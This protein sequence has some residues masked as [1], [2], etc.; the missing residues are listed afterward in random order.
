MKVL[1]PRCS[2]AAQPEQKRCSSC[3]AILPQQAPTGS[4]SQPLALR[5]GI[6][7]LSPTYH[8]KT[9]AIDRLSDLVGRLMEGEE[10]FD[11]LEDHLED[12]AENF[13]EFEEKYAADMQALLAQ[14]S[15]RFPEDDYNLQLSYLLRRGLQLFDEGCRM[16]E[17]FFEAE[18]EDADELDAA[19]RQVREGHDFLC[20]SLE[21]AE[22][23]MHELQAVMKGLESPAEDEDFALELIDEE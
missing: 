16:F 2:A 14:E 18:S 9:P 4:P 22:A 1:C 21:L 13:A 3:G 12:M 10:V 7:Y 5:E 19:F 8:Y 17:A 15:T 20:L 23:R 6:T 11:D